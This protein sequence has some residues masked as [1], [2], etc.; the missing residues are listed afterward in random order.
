MQRNF[1][2][3]MELQDTKCVVVQILYSW[4]KVPAFSFETKKKQ[5]CNEG[6]VL[7]TKLHSTTSVC[8]ERVYANNV[9]SKCVLVG[10]FSSQRDSKSNDQ[11]VTR[12]RK[13]ISRPDLSIASQISISCVLRYNSTLKLHSLC[14]CLSWMRLFITSTILL[15][16]EFRPVSR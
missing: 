1:K 5:R 2:Q 9:V 11:S 14:L 16:E 12:V 10:S 4:Y 15:S 13:K 6:C 3:I 8:H 7:P